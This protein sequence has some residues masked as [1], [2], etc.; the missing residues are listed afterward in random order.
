MQDLK[1]DIH[2]TYEEVRAPV[3]S[4]EGPGSGGTPCAPPPRTEQPQI[5][6]SCGL[7]SSYLPCS[8]VSIVYKVLRQRDIGVFPAKLPYPR[9]PG[10][11]TSRPPDPQTPRVPRPAP[12]TH[13]RESLSAS[14]GP[15]KSVAPRATAFAGLPFNGPITSPAMKLPHWRFAVRYRSASTSANPPQ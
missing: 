3:I 14:G 1:G 7:Y 5:L 10:P 2:S 8:S 15:R 13:P 9:T 6:G 11:Q 4:Y 12:Q